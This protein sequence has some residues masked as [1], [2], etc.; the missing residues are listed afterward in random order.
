MDWTSGYVTDV[1]YT[2]GYYRELNPFF[3]NLLL[4]FSGYQAPSFSTA[5]ELGFGQGV[6][7]NVH[8]ASSPINWYGTD[9]NP[10]QSAFAMQLNDRISGGALIADDD[11]EKFCSR[12]DLPQFDYIGMHGIWSWVS[13]TNREILVDFIGRKLKVGGVLYLSYNTSAGWSPMLPIRELL[14][15]YSKK[16]SGP[17]GGS[18]SRINDS[19]N[20]ARKFQK[21]DPLFIKSNPSIVNRME[22]IYK[23]DRQYVAHEY[24]NDEWSP[25][26]FLQIQKQLLNSK[27]T[28]ATSADPLQSISHLNVSNEQ[29]EILKEI[30]DPGL[31]QCLI[32]LFTNQTF[33]KD[34]W[35]K[36]PQ[37]LTPTQRHNKLR[38]H[39]VALIKN[40]ADIEYKV[41]GPR[42][43]AILKED[44]YRPL[45][46]ALSDYKPR[47][48]GELA[49]KV[50][51]V[52]N[53][54]NVVEAAIVL[55]GMGVIS[56]AQGTSKLKERLPFCRKINREIVARSWDAADIS[57]L[58]SPIIGG[59]LSVS[60]FEQLFLLA[61]DQKVTQTEELADLVWKNLSKRGQKIVKDGKTL[62]SP[63][64]NLEELQRLAKNFLENRLEVLKAM[65]VE[66]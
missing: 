3:A 61:L 17:G 24:F 29:L 1:N 20:F 55:T 31:K 22:Q 21:A 48:L 23:Q 15:E 66:L 57:Y 62:E 44:Q 47:T 51:D 18:I 52:T 39:R 34:Y 43:D 10:S 42:G 4:T 54:G 58:A 50:K 56:F 36:G 2:Y 45:I 7:L 33:R 8:N 13:D 53:F 25:M 28:Y 65:N 41:K 60:R 63:E 12:D 40:I 26:S 32:D 16:M 37:M 46:M 19:L 11:F 35:I 27:V 30:P 38:D 5:C 64:E 59:G 9:F 6:S 14:V 49:E